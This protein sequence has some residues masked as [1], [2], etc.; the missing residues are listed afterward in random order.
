MLSTIDWDTSLVLTVILAPLCIALLIFILT[1]WGRIKELVNDKTSAVNKCTDIKN[2][3]AIKDA[4]FKQTIQQKDNEIERQKKEIERLNGL[5]NA[6]PT[7]LDATP[8]RFD[9]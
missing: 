9:G 6:Q 2:D 4:T 8:R 7:V 1:Q 3:I 5:L